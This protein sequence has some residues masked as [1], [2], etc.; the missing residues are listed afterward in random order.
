VQTRSPF[1]YA[2]REEVMLMA[3]NLSDWVMDLRTQFSQLELEMN[4]VKAKIT[5]G[6]MNPRS[7]EIQYH[8]LEYTAKN[9]SQT[10][11]VINKI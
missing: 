2:L 7:G 9:Q 5:I 1:F 11:M 10:Q 6:L 4:V 8:S 3:K